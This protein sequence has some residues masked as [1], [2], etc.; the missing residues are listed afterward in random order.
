MRPVVT[1]C[2][3]ILDGRHSANN[4]RFTSDERRMRNGGGLDLAGLLDDDWCVKMHPS[5]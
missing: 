2:M 5:F 4:R 3:G 1:T